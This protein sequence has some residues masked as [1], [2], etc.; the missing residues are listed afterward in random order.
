MYKLYGT[1]GSGSAAVEMA[2][3]LA[4]LPYR[5]VRASEWEPDS[6]LD[7]LRKVNPLGQIPTLVAPDGQVMTESAAILIHLGLDAA[8][9]GLLLPGD[10]AARAQAIRGLV[11]I[12][13]NCYSRITV[14]DYPHR[15]TTVADEK[16]LDAIRQGTRKDLHRNWE[17]FADTFTR[18]PF[19]SGDAPGALDCLAAVVSRWSG[20]RAHLQEHRP[21]FHDVLVRIES[22]ETLSPVFE[23]HWDN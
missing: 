15:F 7:E 13:A 20:S 2:L 11:F 23:R 19:L 22:H 16:A 6:A 1:R 10:A 17:V 4:R 5:I 3:E 12:P 18:Q 14:I 21:D 8:S 9:P